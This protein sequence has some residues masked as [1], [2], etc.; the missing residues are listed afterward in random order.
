MRL[1]ERAGIGRRR[2]F[3]PMLLF[4]KRI[5]QY[6]TDGTHVTLRIFNGGF[7]ERMAILMA[8]WRDQGR[9][10]DLDGLLVLT[11]LREHAFIDTL[12]ASEL[13][14]L[15]REPARGVLDQLSQT[16]TGILERRG[17]TK[18]VTYHLNKAVAR[19]LLGKAAYTKTKGVDPIRY[20]E[21]VKVFVDDH[22]V[23]T[24]QE[25]RELLGLGESQT[26]R[27][28]VSRYLKKWSGPGGF[29]QRE[30]TRGPNVRYFPRS[31]E[32]DGA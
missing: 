26:A 23:I 11:Y 28:E 30:G 24:P 19:D 4:G 9:E 2:I 1:V 12:A 10:I 8:K 25:C 7:D 21:M 32:T 13:L 3:I 15:P 17:K 27:V 22:G 29:L 31:G 14:Q 16:K 6:E 20:R 5:P 18:T